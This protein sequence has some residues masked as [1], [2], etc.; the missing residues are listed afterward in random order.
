MSSRSRRH[1]PARRAALVALVA[2]AARAEI[3][4]APTSARGSCAPRASPRRSRARDAEP[5]GP[6]LAPRASPRAAV[7]R[8]RAARARRDHLQDRRPTS[9]DGARPSASRSSQCATAPIAAARGALGVVGCASS[10][11]T[12]PDRARWKWRRSR[13]AALDRRHAR[14]LQPGGAAGS[15]IILL[16]HRRGEPL[17][18]RARPGGD[19][20]G[21]GAE[22]AAQRPRPARRAAA[23][24]GRRVCGA[25]AGAPATSAR[26]RRAKRRARHGREPSTTEEE[27]AQLE[28]RVFADP[29]ADAVQASSATSRGGARGDGAG[30]SP[31]DALQQEGHEL[32]A[33]RRSRG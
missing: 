7:A 13:R 2:A 26:R 1:R 6:G 10:V 17:H 3:R 20:A 16:R 8:R 19:D 14:V 30:E 9:S 33:R 24:A 15:E 22:G 25:T 11:A 31:L 21:A 28:A 4:R 32:D 18:R 23:A 29:T 5:R 27:R 12:P